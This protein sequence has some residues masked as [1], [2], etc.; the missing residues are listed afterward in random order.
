MPG[1]Q[2]DQ[3]YLPDLPLYLVEAISNRREDASYIALDQLLC[4]D[5]LDAGNNVQSLRVAVSVRV[6]ARDNSARMSLEPDGAG[7]RAVGF[8]QSETG[9]RLGKPFKEQFLKI[10]KNKDH[11][12]QLRIIVEAKLQSKIVPEGDNHGADFWQ[13]DPWFLK[14]WLPGMGLSPQHLSIVDYEQQAILRRSSIISASM[15]CEYLSQLPS[16]KC[17]F[18]IDP[19]TCHALDLT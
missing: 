14:Q 9:G 16:A 17:E 19:F 8:F 5:W 13:T 12:V 18:L 10:M 15:S 1:H 2:W 3:D 7:P 4:T 6:W 11:I